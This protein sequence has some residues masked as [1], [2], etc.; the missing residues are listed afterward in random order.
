LISEKLNLLRSRKAAI[1]SYKKMSK[2]A[3]LLPLIEKE[4]ELYILFEKRAQSLKRQP[5]EICFPGGG[6]ESDDRNP[7]EAAIRETS[8]ELGIDEEDIDVICPLDIV[9]SP[10]NA[11]IYPYLAV[12][13]KPEKIAHNNFEVE[14]IIL[15]PMSFLNNHPPQ[16]E[17]LKISL[18]PS[19]DYPFHLIPHGINYPFRA[20]RYPQF[21]YKYEETVVWGLT[22]LILTHFLELFNSQ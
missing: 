14:D 15:I 12:I 19:E 9:V 11:I 18:E 13:N 16:V 5:G 20:S 6:I 17:Y 8:E 22:A 10:F 2:S 7:M 1:L 3:V 21:F 4:N